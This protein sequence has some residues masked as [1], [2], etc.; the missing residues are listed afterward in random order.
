MFARAR[1][2]ALAAVTLP[3]LAVWAQGEG[4]SPPERSYETF[5]RLEAHE[6]EIA[7]SAAAKARP[8][9]DHLPE[10]HRRWLE[11][12]DVLITDEERELFLSLSKDYQR[13]AF[14]DA[15]WKQRD[16]YPDTAR[17]EA[18]QRWD[19]A[20]AN[21]RLHFDDL[22]GDVRA[23]FMLLNGV[24][25]SDHHIDCF[26]HRLEVWYYEWSP[27]TPLRF[28]VIFQPRW[29]GGPWKRWDPFDRSKGLALGRVANFP[30]GVPGCDFGPLFDAMRLVEEINEGN[31]YRY[32]ILMERLSRPDPPPAREWIATFASYSTDVP[33]GAE[34]FGAE[35]SFSF[36]GWRQSRTVVQGL[37]EVPLAAVTA[38]ELSGHRAYAFSLN[39]E[40]LGADGKLFESF[41]YRF[42]FGPEDVRGDR[43]PLVFQRYL[44]PG[45]YRL[46]LRLDDLAGGRY[47]R[48]ESELTVP[49]LDA[50]RAPA[51]GDPLIAEL[52]AGANRSIADG[53]AGV[54]IVMPRR[55]LLAG[56]VRFDVAAEGET[57]DHVTFWLDGQA[58]FTKREPPYSVELDFGDLPR[59]LVL[60]ATAH[61]ASGRQIAS[62]E[63]LLNASP[64]R[65]SVRLVDPAPGVAYHGSVRAR[66]D[67]QVPEGEVLDRVELYRGDVRLATL[68][69]P[70]FTQPLL[71]PPGD[72]QV[73]VR[74]VGYLAGGLQDEDVVLVNGPPLG[75]E[76]GVD[77][78]ELYASVLDRQRR[79]VLGLEANAFRIFEDGREQ[80]LR[81]FEHVS[82]LP[83]HATILLD[84]SASMEE[85][86]D[87]TREAALTFFSSTVVPGGKDRVA[88]ITFNDHPQVAVSFTNDPQRFATGLAGLQAER[89]TALY[90][91]L[92]YALFY[93]NG[94]QGHRA[95]L[96][97]SDGVD[98]SSR[99]TFE[100]ALDYAR[101]SEATIYSIGLALDGGD[102]RDARRILR[103]LAEE[104]GGRSFFID[105]AGELGAVYDAIRQELRAKYLLAYQ[106]D[107][108]S[109]EGFR[110]VRVKVDR[111]GLQAKTIRGYYP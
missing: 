102:L 53:E 31:P 91:S 97:L 100:E 1:W 93:S 34:T 43:L 98:E 82:D 37:I 67:V 39:G 42:E 77:F 65:F 50:T 109:G 48:R 110:Q 7:Q 58:I 6:S 74:A 105:D 38:A 83:I 86:L 8:I 33:E 89:S 49:R 52:F 27:R 95:I 111:R 19:E 21:A 28:P 29:R 62:D 17:N 14:I 107:N 84:V 36:P 73:L 76:I 56:L 4:P 88:V 90:D 20:V 41:R 51:A 54:R 22:A 47:C 32:S 10:A 92:I 45:D 104:T 15:F 2:G 11:E 18:R 80:Q 44:R 26:N 12:I 96:L 66:V 5:R 99:F 24:P 71:L 40:V 68:Y 75:E 81:R 46:V 55:D 63:R 103:R 101:R 13:D 64:H 59:T 60:R 78:V 3:A 30:R 70:P 94:L 72:E 9:P 108:G 87:Q 25:T 16:P 35:V 106:S 61:D 57:I 85:R 23:R 79:P 69:E